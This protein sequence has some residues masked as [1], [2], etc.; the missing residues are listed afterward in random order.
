MW[1]T[2]VMTPVKHSHRF[3]V[4][5]EPAEEGGF[6]VYIPALGIATQ[7]ETVEEARA[8]AED[9][10]VGRLEC[11]LEEG[12]PIPEEHVHGREKIFVEQLSV[13]L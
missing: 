1:Y 5:F 9:A 11:L 3:T 2:G 12:Q 4:V 10:I 8:M 13:N 7:G 6:V